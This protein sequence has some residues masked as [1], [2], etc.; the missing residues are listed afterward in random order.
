MKKFDRYLLFAAK[1]NMPKLAL[2]ML[3]EGANPNIEDEEGRSL[4][5]IVGRNQEMLNLS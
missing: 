1:K 5:E 3:R 2:L 4:L